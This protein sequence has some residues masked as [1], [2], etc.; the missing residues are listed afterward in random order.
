M[1]TTTGK[2]KRANLSLPRYPNA[3]GFD[4]P[5]NLGDLASFDAK[6]LERQCLPRPASAISRLPRF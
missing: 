1:Y 6:Q 3:E 5:D 4:E 2:P